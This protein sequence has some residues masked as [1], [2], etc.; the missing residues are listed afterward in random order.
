MTDLDPDYRHQT[1]LRLSLAF[2]VLFSIGSV[3]R[4]F[5]EFLPGYMVWMGGLNIVL[6]FTIYLLIRGS[7][8]PSA[9]PA[10]VI[11]LCLFV[12]LQLLLT[13]GGVNSQYAYF[14][15]LIP[16][17]T[18]LVGSVRLTWVVCALLAA[19]VICMFLLGDRIPDLTEYPFLEEKTRVRSVWLIVSVVIASYFG[20]YFRKTYDEQ[21][22]LLDKLASIDHL[23]GL[24]NRRGLKA[25]LDQELQRSARSSQPLSILM[26]DVDFFKR[27]NDQHGHSAGDDCLIKVARCLRKHTRAEDIVSRYGG[28][29]FL[30]VLINANVAET[31]SVAEKLRKA[32]SELDLL[33][34][35]ERISVT[36][37]A[38]SMAPAQTL[39]DMPTAEALIREAD[40]ALYRGKEAG[41]NRVEYAQFS[42]SN[43]AYI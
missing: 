11:V 3:G 41:R 27:F 16:M 32:V 21:S 2:A 29:E 39:V 15:A 5:V 36:I 12:L 34:C 31:L 40:K 23:T 1:M 6:S 35:G 13:T 33:A 9:E 14:M 30:L 18:A 17:I 25:R 38:A 20:V 37:G 10:M 22:A 42:G 19:L 43:S 26:V 24:V 7:R 4:F 28:E 8:F